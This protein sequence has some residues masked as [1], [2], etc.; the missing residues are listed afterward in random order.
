MIRR[1]PLPQLELGRSHQFKKVY[2]SKPLRRNKKGIERN[3]KKSSF[4]YEAEWDTLGFPH[5][6]H[7]YQVYSAAVVSAG[8]IAFNTTPLVISPTKED[9]TSGGCQPQP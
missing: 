4:D 9:F 2:I 1:K 7:H 5:R 3:K 6:A 8:N